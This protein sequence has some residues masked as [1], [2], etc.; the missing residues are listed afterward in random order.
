SDL[1]FSASREIDLER[2][3]SAINAACKEAERACGGEFLLDR[4]TF[5]PGPQGDHQRQCYKGRVYS[6]DF[7]GQEDD[8]TISVKVDVTEFDRLHLPAASRQLIHPYSDAAAC[9]AELRCMALEEI[10]ANKMKC[11][12]QRRHSHDLFDLV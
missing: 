8:L 12:I 1:D 11:L 7:Y 10:V 4:N 6:P 5:K 2:M 9:S 3:A